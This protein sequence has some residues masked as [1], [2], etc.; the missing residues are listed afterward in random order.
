MKLC[1]TT[2]LVLCSVISQR[3]LTHVPRMGLFAFILN[4]FLKDLPTH[5]LTPTLT[6]LIAHN[7][8]IRQQ[9]VLHDATFSHSHLL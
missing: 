5:Q 9:Q 4:I 7:R 3:A 1:Y 2:V 6:D 8:V